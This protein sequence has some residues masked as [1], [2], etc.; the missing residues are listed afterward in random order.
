MELLGLVGRVVL[1]LVVVLALLW[2]A[3]RG[4]RNNQKRTLR[5]VE[6]DV[7]ARQPL[8]RSAS[9]AVVR[10][11]DRALVLGVTEGRV[12]LLSD[13]PLSELLTPELVPAAPG[14]DLLPTAVAS[15]VVTDL[16][17]PT[18]VTTTLGERV[19]V[20]APT[21]RSATRSAAR[22]QQDGGRLAGSALSPQTWTKALDAVR[23]LTVRR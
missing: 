23:E 14:D 16:G 21:T 17:A 10:L 2:L 11:G 19:L 20:P 9:V 13:R 4:L 8:A 5:G 7:L 18:A 15:D 6:M 3:A 1:S 22:G 12:D